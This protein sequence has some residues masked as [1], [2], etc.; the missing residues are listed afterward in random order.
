MSVGGADMDIELFHYSNLDE[1]L[2]ITASTTQSSP[3]GPLIFQN[4]LTTQ[5]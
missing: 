1:Q 3:L 2:V 5:N 4:F